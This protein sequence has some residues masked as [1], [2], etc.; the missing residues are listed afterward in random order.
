VNII[1][2]DFEWG[3]TTEVIRGDFAT[4]ITPDNLVLNNTGS[5]IQNNTTPKP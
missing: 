4:Q 5:V 2:S 1:K 3:V